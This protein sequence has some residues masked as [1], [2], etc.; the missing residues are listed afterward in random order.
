MKK[1]NLKLKEVT[2]KAY[3]CVIGACPSV[4]KTDRNTYV[5]VGKLI[6]NIKDID[7]LAQKVGEGE[8]AIELPKEIIDSIINSKKH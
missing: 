2:P 4:F 5:I 6:D 3:Q 8:T 1:E 7:L